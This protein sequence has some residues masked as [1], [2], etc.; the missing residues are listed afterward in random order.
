M[1]PANM[2]LFVNARSITLRQLNT[3]TSLDTFSCLGGR[4]VTLQTG[5]REAPGLVPGTGMSAFFC[6]TVVI[7]VVVVAVVVF[8]FFCPKI[9]FK[10]NF[11]IPFAKLI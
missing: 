10:Y 2:A 9:H 1:W 6:F 4:E 8:L 7:V 5:V 3:F 11:A